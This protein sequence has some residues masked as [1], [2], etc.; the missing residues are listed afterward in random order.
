MFIAASFMVIRTLYY[1]FLMSPRFYSF[2]LSL[3]ARRVH[4][5]AD[6]KD[7][8]RAPNAPNRNSHSP[9][10]LRVTAKG[11]FFPSSSLLL[12]FVREP[13]DVCGV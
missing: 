8:G 7:S 4:L 12:L 3:A 9:F 13:V 11:L 5:I 1:S 2:T 6:K 10:Q